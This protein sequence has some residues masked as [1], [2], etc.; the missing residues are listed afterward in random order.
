MKRIVPTPGQTWMCFNTT[1]RAWAEPTASMVSLI[2]ETPGRS[3]GNVRRDV[4][5]SA[6][7]LRKF[8][9]A[10]QEASVPTIAAPRWDRLP[11]RAVGY[12]VVVPGRPWHSGQIVGLQRPVV[13]PRGLKVTLAPARFRTIVKRLS[14]VSARPTEIPQVRARRRRSPQVSH[15]QDGIPRHT[16]AHLLRW[17]CKPVTSIYADQAG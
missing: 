15:R 6:S 7:F 12:R 17:P 8:V 4:L 1:L 10:S 2:E 3:I 5:P 14:S 13:S 11:C 16:A 9:E